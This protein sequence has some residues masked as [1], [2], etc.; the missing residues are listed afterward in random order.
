MAKLK[1]LKNDFAK[2]K[3]ELANVERDLVDVEF[4][5]A[6][7]RPRFLELSSQMVSLKA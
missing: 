2:V 1:I 4:T 6:R 3:D 7:E 5:K